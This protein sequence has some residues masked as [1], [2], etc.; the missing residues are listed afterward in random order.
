MDNDTLTVTLT[1]VDWLDSG[2]QPQIPC[3]HS[4]FGGSEEKLADRFR[5]PDGGHYTPDEIDIFYRHQSTE[6][7]VESGVLGL[8]DR[9]TG[10]YILEMTTS[11]QLIEKLIYAVKQYGKRTDTTPQYQIDLRTET[12]Q[13]ATLKNDTLLVYGTDEPLLRRQSLIPSGIEI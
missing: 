13:L 11:P 5:A 8:A 3:L 12:D 7:P 6:P 4:Q 2:Q 1:N 9:L 10:E